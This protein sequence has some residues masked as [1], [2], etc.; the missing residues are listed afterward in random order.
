[1]PRE[2]DLVAKVDK[3][4]QLDDPSSKLSIM[5][6]GKQPEIRIKKINDGPEE[7][8]EYEAALQVKISDTSQ[9]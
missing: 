3:I 1:M 7:M 8:K 9:M 4:T 5:T 6:G 2:Y